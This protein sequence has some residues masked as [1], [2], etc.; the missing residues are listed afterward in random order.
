[1]QLYEFSSWTEEASKLVAVHLKGLAAR[2]AS[3]ESEFDE[4]LHHTRSLTGDWRSSRRAVID[5]V[6]VAEKQCDTFVADPSLPYSGFIWTILVEDTF[7]EIQPQLIT[8]ID[9]RPHHSSE[10]QF[11]VFRL[12]DNSFRIDQTSEAGFRE[13][14]ADEHRIASMT[15]QELLDSGEAIALGPGIRCLGT[16]NTPGATFYEREERA[17]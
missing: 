10:A 6:R 5:W 15:V 9:S 3:R 13:W 4:P 14:M 7:V 11:L 17:S 8:V 16:E 2:C 12:G 1:M